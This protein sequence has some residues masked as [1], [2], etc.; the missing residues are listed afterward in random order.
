MV[1]KHLKRIAAPKTW[2]ISRKET[3]YITRQLPGP[4][5]KQ[6]SMPLSLVIREL[7]KFAKSAKDAKQIINFK[8][9][10]VDKKKRTEEKHPVGL[11]DI[12]EFPQVEERFRILLDS[13]GKLCA[14]KA[15]D[16][17]AATKLLRIEAKTKLKGGKIQLNMSD[18]RN[19]PAE[20]DIYK[21]GDTLQISLPDQKILE[22]FKLDKNMTVLL[23]GGKHSGMIAKTEEIG[24]DN[25]IIKTAK[26]QRSEMMKRHAFIVGADKPA[27]E[28]IK[29]LMTAK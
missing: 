10:F 5:T 13:K 19:L 4:H 20:K 22:H 15:A 26:N 18:G 6:H 28:S 25:I 12:V 9:V 24:K 11:M 29:Q 17:E 21:V 14:V 7:I 16:K 3:K 1:K 2:R 23:I 27:L 8:D